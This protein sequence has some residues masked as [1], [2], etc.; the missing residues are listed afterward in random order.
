MIPR[1][2]VPSKLSPVIPQEEPARPRR[3]STVLDKRTLVPAHMPFVTLDTRS[4]IPDYVPLD[5]LSNRVL[6]PR[7]AVHGTLDLPP[8]A[9]AWPSSDMDERIAVPR[10]A[11]PE[12]IVAEAPVPFE[13]IE[14][15]LEP[16]VL[17]TG[18]VN[19]L[20][21]EV[22]AGRKEQSPLVPLMSLGVHAGFILIVFLVALIFP[23]R[24]PTQ[25]EL[26]LARNQLGIV[27]LPNSMFSEPK[28]GPPSAPPGPP[29]RVSPRVL[30]EAAPPS[31]VPSLSEP[32]RVAREL[33]SAP[34]PAAPAP[35]AEAPRE[36]ARFEPPKPLPDTPSAITLPRFS[37]GKALEQ[38]VRGGA[39]VGAAHGPTIVGPVARSRGGIGRSGGGGGGGGGASAQG[40][41]EMLTPTEGVDFD[42]YL[43]RVYDKVKLNWET[44]MPESVWLGEKGIVVLEFRIMRDG[45]VPPA[46]PTLMGSNARE[47]LQTAAISSI[48]GSNPFAPLPPA[49][50]GP[51][52]L[53]RFSYFYNIQPDSIK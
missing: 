5:V 21:R 9:R 45:T 20:P 34:L 33:P 13:Q 41:L 8:A 36:T 26:D 39:D 28:A 1:T 32:P 19:L 42:S 22:S 35:R 17:T 49:F 44:V 16:D 25:A 7:D 38:S 6:V 12:S 29:I 31:P 50:S 3:V 37:A 40:G 48:R 46:E 2:L 51:Y 30:R 52:I 23:A 11:H 24:R 43:R 47:P 4:A 14:D 18:D 15:L 10:D 27:Y 53:L